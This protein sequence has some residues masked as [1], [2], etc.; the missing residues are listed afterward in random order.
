[1]TAAATLRGIMCHLTACS[2]ALCKL[3]DAAR[4]FGRLL[5]SFKAAVGLLVLL[6]LLAVVGPVVAVLGALAFGVVLVVRAA[7]GRPVNPKLSGALKG[8][9]DDTFLPTVKPLAVLAVGGVGAGLVIG[10][11]GVL[12]SGPDYEVLYEKDMT[13]TFVSM[14]GYD[15]VENGGILYIKVAVDDPQDVNP[16]YEDLAEHPKVNEYDCVVVDFF[17]QGGRSGEP[18]DG[19]VIEGTPSCS[20]DTK[21][22]EQSV[23]SFSESSR[24]DDIY[25]DELLRGVEDPEGW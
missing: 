7:G 9:Y 18:L 3:R 1:M 16:V 22:Y 24:I 14:S 2:R 6:T 20:S 8:F 10:L 11:A 15:Y 17:A 12:T 25:G 21:F 23:D 4:Q 19:R 5:P 13:G